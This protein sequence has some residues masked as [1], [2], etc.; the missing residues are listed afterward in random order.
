MTKLQYLFISELREL[1]TKKEVM[2]LPGPLFFNIITTIFVKKLSNQIRPSQSDIKHS[3]LNNATLIG[4]AGY[5][6]LDYQV[7]LFTQARINLQAP[8]RKNQK[9]YKPYHFIFRR[10]RKRIDREAA[11]KVNNIFPAF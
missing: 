3:G 6:S 11:P 7:D 9:D 5:V 1:L 2:S 10:S 8:M 4:D